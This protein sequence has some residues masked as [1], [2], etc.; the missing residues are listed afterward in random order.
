[1]IL[2]AKYIYGPQVWAAVTCSNLLSL[3]QCPLK[4][5]SVMPASD[6]VRYT[7]G[8]KQMLGG[9]LLHILCKLKSL[10]SVDIKSD[11]DEVQCKTDQVDIIRKLLLELELG[12]LRIGS[13]VC[14]EDVDSGIWLGSN[15]SYCH[16]PMICKPRQLHYGGQAQGLSDWSE[17]VANEDELPI[18]WRSF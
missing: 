7:L 17:R 8:V 6:D 2:N 11:C 15:K 18:G 3:L 4:T 16:D 5:L 9:E 1:M 14:P 12:D 10:L 13:F